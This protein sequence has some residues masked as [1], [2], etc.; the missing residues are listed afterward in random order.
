VRSAAAQ[1]AADRGLAGKHVV[2]LSRSSI[3]PFLVFS[4]RRDLRDKAFD[5]WTRRGEMGGDTDNRSL[6]AETVKLRAE[7]AKL[8]GFDTFAGFRLADAMAKTP[9]AVRGLLERVWAPAR[10]RAAREAE[11]L[12]A[13]IAGEGGNFT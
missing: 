5:A 7:R 12:Q 2:T 6:I 3:E 4:T 11:A 1:A 8:L 13:L 9:E 10:A